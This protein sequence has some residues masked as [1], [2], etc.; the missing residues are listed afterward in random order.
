[1]DYLRRPADGNCWW[2]GE[3]ADSREHKY[4]RTDL[5]RLQ[6]EGGPLVWG[7][8][9]ERSHLIRSAKKSGAVRFN[10]S[11]CRACNGDRSQPFDRAYDEY[12]DFLWLHVDEMW[13]WD[14]LPMEWI[15][16]S[17]WP[18]RQ[19]D[20]A[21]Y[22]AKHFGCRIA[23]EGLE[24][25]RG[26]ISLMDGG[27]AAPNIRMCFSKR[28]DIWELHRGLRGTASGVT[29]L[30]LGGMLAHLTQDRSRILSLETNALVGYIG[31]EFLWDETQ[32]D[33]DSFF[34]HAVPILN[35][36][37]AHPEV[38]ELIRARHDEREVETPG[39]SIRVADK[40]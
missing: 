31:V 13:E 18:I 1:M 34:P 38:I 19:L 16:G 33:W 11:L 32:A 37:P 22:F 27:E 9:P 6:R 35:E 36:M 10:R 8:D 23:E 3:V 26:I 40:D 5:E 21:R 2:C 14:G 28:Q 25:P 29:G 30:W 17:H 15:F 7:G 4:K 39:N 20:L 24:V 12:V